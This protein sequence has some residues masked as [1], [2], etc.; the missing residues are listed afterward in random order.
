MFETFHGRD[1]KNENTTVRSSI[2][3]VSKGL[4]ALLPCSIPYLLK[5]RKGHAKKTVEI[6]NAQ[7][8]QK[9][10]YDTCNNTT[11]PSI[12]TSF[13]KKSAPIVAL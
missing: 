2:E 7:N 5:I 4:K 3:R 8:M 6:W 10:R 12:S 1:I 11:L 9:K 13:V